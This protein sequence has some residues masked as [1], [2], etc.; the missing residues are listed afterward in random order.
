MPD[1][2]V[3]HHHTD[4]GS[5]SMG[6][7]Y[8]QQKCEDIGEIGANACRDLEFCGARLPYIVNAVRGLLA[9]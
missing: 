1:A 3:S 5:T 2:K 9:E 7:D 4:E 8:F 6:F